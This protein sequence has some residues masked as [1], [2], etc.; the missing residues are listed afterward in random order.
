VITAFLNPVHAQNIYSYA[1]TDSTE[2]LINQKYIIDNNWLDAI[3]QLPPNLHSATSIETTFF[4]INKE[5]KDNKIYFFNLKESRFLIRNGRKI[6]LNNIENIIELYKRKRINDNYSA[7]IT[8]DKI[9]EN[10]YSLA[11]DRYIISKEIVEMKK[12]LSNYQLTKLENIATIKKSQLFKDETIGQE[13][14]VI[15]PSDFSQSYYT[16]E[17]GKKIYISEQYNKYETYKLMQNDILLSTKGTI[18]NVAI[19]GEISKPVLA[20]QAIEIIRLKDKNKAIELYMFL[21][22]NIG[23]ALLM[24]LVSG[25]AMPQISTK[26]LR[27][28]I[29]PSFTYTQREKIINNFTIEK[30]MFDEMQTIQ[31][32]IENLHNN[33]LEG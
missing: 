28:L 13:T 9:I 18:G 17:C 21:K 22:S 32:R 24:Q 12:K 29:V 1:K 20:S 6:I 15:S 31:R 2:Y 11:I 14:W 33:F 19:V 27:K 7:L 26:E 30:D 25:T 4:I 10:N 8:R 3:I 16:K 5:K 23:Q